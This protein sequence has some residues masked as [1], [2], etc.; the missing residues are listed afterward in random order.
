MPKVSFA[1][2]NK[3]KIPEI[4]RFVLENGLVAKGNDACYSVQIR[5]PTPRPH[6][7]ILW[8]T[9]CWAWGQIGNI[10]IS[11]QDKG[12]NNKNWVIEV[13]GRENV[14]HMKTLA[15]KISKK[16]NV[17]VHVRL[18][19]EKTRWWCDDIRHY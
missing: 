8:F 18:E 17:N 10:Y 5:L 15:E 11:N 19:E 9:M 13:C 6:A 14:D 4:V 3:L 16:F 1:E 7:K 2:S 12:A